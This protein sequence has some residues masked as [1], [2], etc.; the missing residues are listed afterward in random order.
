MGSSCEYSRLL[1][2]KEEEW[3]F[4]VVCNLCMGLLVKS[5]KGMFGQLGF[6]VWFS[7]EIYDYSLASSE[8]CAWVLQPVLVLSFATPFR[9]C[10]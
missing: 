5:Q 1:D 9:L 6:L 10:G 4:F 3:I 7:V 8:L 2:F